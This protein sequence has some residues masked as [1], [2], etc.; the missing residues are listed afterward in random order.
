MVKLSKRLEAL[1]ELVSAGARVC[2]VGCD[3]GWLSISLVQSGKCPKA[4]AMDINH[5]PLDAAR[6]HVEACCLEDAIELR[7]SDGLTALKAQEADA[8]VIAGMG[9]AL[10][11]R[12]LAAGSEVLKSVKELILSPQSEV[13]SVRFYLRKH[14]WRICAETMILEDGK[15]YFLMKAIHQTSKDET[16]SGQADF[17][18]KEV[19]SVEDEYGPVLLQTRPEVFLQWL[20]RE[21]KISASILANLEAA[22]DTEVN[23]DRIAAVKE[24]FTQMEA[25]YNDV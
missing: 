1:A 7:L 25:I 14:G 15:Y 2:D 6:A 22:A 5:G 24:R 4:I 8:V 13:P 10:I 17:S 20:K 23:A 12:I 16:D 21:M 11:R 19:F 3:H 18:E 9:G